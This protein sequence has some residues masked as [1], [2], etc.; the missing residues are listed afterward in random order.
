MDTL[1]RESYYPQ[2]VGE[3]LRIKDMS[4]G[5]IKNQLEKIEAT[6]IN[7]KYKDIFEQELKHRFKHNFV[8]LI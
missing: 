4:Y 7:S 6:E 5:C 3:P 2:M 8:S 1:T